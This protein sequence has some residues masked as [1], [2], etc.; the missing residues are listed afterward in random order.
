MNDCY[1]ELELTNPCM[2]LLSEG[3]ERACFAKLCKYYE[4][5]GFRR[6]GRNNHFFFV[7][8]DFLGKCARG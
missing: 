4:K 6:I 1:V 5:I 8:D 2:S 7:V 3:D